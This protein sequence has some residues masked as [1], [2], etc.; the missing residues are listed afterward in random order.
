[1]NIFRNLPENQMPEELVEVLEQREHMR[2]ERIVSQGHCSPEGFWYDQEEDEWVLI[3][4]G[5]AVLELEDGVQK[6]L[7]IGDYFMLPAHYKHRVA[8]TS[9]QPPCIWLCV[10]SK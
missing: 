10:F 6:R 4:Q 7:H 1:M 2:M 9:S 5:E 3:V 8:W